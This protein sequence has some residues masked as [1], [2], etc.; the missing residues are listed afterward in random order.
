MS[1]L[2]V[3][4]RGKLT[5]FAADLRCSNPYRRSLRGA[6]L[7]VSGLEGHVQLETGCAIRI[8]SSLLGGAHLR[9]A[10]APTQPKDVPTHRSR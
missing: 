7:G 6:G 10:M 5:T 9:L 3:S 8:L 2:E 1:Y 4:L